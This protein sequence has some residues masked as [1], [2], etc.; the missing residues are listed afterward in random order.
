MLDGCGHFVVLQRPESDFGGA[1]EKVCFPQELN[2]ILLWVKGGEE[3]GMKAIG[4]MALRCLFP[5]RTSH[6]GNSKK[7]RGR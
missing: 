4:A 6:G 5:V 7:M 1:Q 2:A 3:K